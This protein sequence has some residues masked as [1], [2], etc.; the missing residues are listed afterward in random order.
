MLSIAKGLLEKEAKQSV[1]DKTAHMAQNCPELSL[2][3][4]VQEL[5]VH[6]IHSLTLNWLQTHPY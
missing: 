1:E 6:H 5:Q 4:S 3:H 2:P